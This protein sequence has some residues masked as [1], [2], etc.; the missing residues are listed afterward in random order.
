M[1]TGGR[2]GLKMNSIFNTTFALLLEKIAKVVYRLRWWFVFPQILLSLLCFLY[3]A[4]VLKLDMN[5]NH[6]IGPNVK[7]EQAYRA[8][9]KEFP[10][11]GSEIVVVV[12]S[13]RSEHNRQFIE[14]L[15]A[16]VKPET[17]LFTDLFYKADFT[18][19]GP[20]ALLLAPTNALEHLLQALG[21]HGPL[22]GQF[23]QAT[24]LDSLFSTVNAQFQNRS[25][26]TAS[27]PRSLVDAIPSLQ[28]V[29]A[30]A[31]EAL[32]HPGRPPPP[33]VESLFFGG[34][35]TQKQIYLSV[36]NGRTYFLTARP[37][38]EALSSEAIERLRQ[39]IEATQTELPGLNVGLTGGPVL[40][41]D[42]MRQAKHDTTR[43][44]ALAFILSTVLFIIAYRQVWRPLKAV[45]CLLIGLGFSLG[46]ATLSIGHLNILTITFAPMLIGLAIDFGIHF[47]SRYEEEMRNRRT[48]T[49]A[50]E[51]ASAFT[52]QGIVTGALTTAAAF[53]AMAL[54]RFRGIQEM[55]IISGGG[56]L[57]CLIPMMTALPVLL[58]R[59]RQNIRDHQLGPAG[60]R[61]L[62]IEILWLRH[63]LIV[64]TVALLLCLAATLQF[65]R[66]SFDYDLL[67]MQN[68]A[69]ASVQYEKQ[70]IKSAGVSSLYGVVTADSAELAREYEERLKKLPAVA[71]VRSA[72]DFLTDGQAHKLELVTDIKQELESIRFAPA[73]QSQVNLKSLSVTLWY[74]SGYLGLASD[75]AEKRDPLIAKDLRSLKATIARFRVL[76][77]R[78]DP[79]IR[80]KMTEFQQALFK[81]LHDTF[82]AI[83]SQDTRA[84]LLQQDLPP[85]LRHRFIGNTGKYLV[86]VYPRKDLWQHENQRAFIDQ[87]LSVVPANNVTGTPIHLYEYTTLLKKSYE[88]AADY[89]LVA[90]VI[91]LLLHF[92]SFLSA[93][94]ALLPVAVGTVW[95]LGLMGLMRVPFNPANIMTLPLVLGIGVTNGVQIL[96]RFAEEQQ[97]SILA[98]STGKAVLVSGLTAI[99]GF[100]S[101]ILSEHQGIRSLGIVMSLGIAA[102]MIAALTILPTLLGIL[103][104]HG[105]SF[106]NVPIRRLPARLFHPH[107]PPST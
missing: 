35:G 56:L 47:I 83:Q 15:A 81:N 29:I 43:A 33:E 85:A 73:D 57:L 6:L 78:P 77:L 99:I 55:G 41:Y 8:F 105:K 103:M 53:L 32:L 69:L 26:G 21:R 30:Q 100:G 74:L 60:Q 25:V 67:H 5:R 95:L 49:E 80:K 62:K 89:A 4:N 16:K 44:S 96:N 54:T 17:N 72:A 104:H 52:G 40:D 22:I 20:K 107:R 64:V 39:L 76:M 1:R 88:E 13:G 45:I 12:E 70:L 90:I 48:G 93:L 79:Q 10:A 36:D 50:V 42:E 37:G 86:Q 3:T 61:R 27:E 71:E 14:R 46:F 7:S 24:N 92:R 38:T 84:P 97:P 18:T 58:L 9:Q 94:L 11:E 63:P 82:H 102:C 68:Q 34:K 31:S 65:H 66:V 2:I 59:G 91:M 75:A 87:L 106:E 23:S 98:K 28:G 51:R 101:L 19:L